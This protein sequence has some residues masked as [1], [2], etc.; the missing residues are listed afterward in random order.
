MIVA[1]QVPAPVP[2][3]P[4]HERQL[5]YVCP[6]LVMTRPTRLVVRRTAGGRRL[7]MMDNYLYN[8]GPGR[9]QFRGHR[10]SARYRMDARQLVDRTGGRRPDSV[11]TGA[12]LTWKYVDRRRGNFWKFQNAARFELWRTNDRGERTALATTGPK[13]DYCLRDLFRFGRGPRVPKRWQFGA[14]SQ[15]LGAATVTLGIAIGWAD[16]YPYRYPQNWIDVTGRRGCF[17]VVHRADPLN[18]VLETDEGDN[19]NQRVVRLPYRAGPQRCPSY[20]GVG[21]P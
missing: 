15:D 2:A 7:L 8:R 13:L 20:R 9:V 18:H 11:F 17:V 21:V 5:H 12:R 6:N 16:G 10:G 14:C 4:C 3:N 19:T 1:D